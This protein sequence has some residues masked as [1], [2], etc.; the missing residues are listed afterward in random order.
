MEICSCTES[1]SKAA[2]VPDKR[3]LTKTRHTQGPLSPVDTE[4]K[5]SYLLLHLQ[6]LRT[7]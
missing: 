4:Q 7:E 6:K 5:L 3:V 2:Q 1:C